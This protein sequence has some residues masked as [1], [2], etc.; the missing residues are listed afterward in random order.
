MTFVAI[1]KPIILCIVTIVKKK[2]VIMPRK[3]FK[4]YED[5]IKFGMRWGFSII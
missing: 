5:I 4:V 3:L 1:S 2:D